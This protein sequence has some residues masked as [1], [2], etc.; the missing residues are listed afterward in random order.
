MPQGL[1]AFAQYQ[2]YNC[3][4]S[5]ITAQLVPV[6][7]SLMAP[8]HQL[9]YARSMWVQSLCLDISTKGMPVNQMDML[10][11]L[12]FLQQEADKALGALH[13]FCDAIWA[14]RLNPNSWQQVEVHFYEVL[15]LPPVWKYDFKTKQR[16]RGTDRDSLEKLRD[17]YPSVQPFVNAVLAYREAVKLAGVFKKGLEADNTLRCN[18]SPTGTETRRLS[19][20]TNPFGRGT[21]AQNLNDR[22]RQVIEAPAGYGLAYIDLKTAE[23]FAVGFISGSLPYIEAC[24]SGDLHTAVARDTWQELAWTGNLKTDKAIAEERFY[25]DFSRRDMTKK[26]GHASNYYGKPAQIHKHTKIDKRLIE[27]FQ[28]RYFGRYPE[29]PE[30][31]LRTIANIQQTGIIEN[32]FGLQRMFWGR[33]DDEATWREAIAHEPQGTVAEIINQGLMQVQVWL[34]QQERLLREFPRT[35]LLMQVHDAGLFCFPIPAFAE[36]VAETVQRIKVPVH[37]KGIGTMEIPADSQA[38]KNWGKAKFDKAKG[39]WKNPA[40]LR[41]YAPG[42]QLHFS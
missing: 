14:P 22:V 37:Y 2:V 33:R 42:D 15:D 24:S 29:I 26:L 36:L 25:R 11:L 7:E 1:N 40:G 41:D 21:N 32:V 10:T 6:M 23:S 17:T 20:Q 27:E 3:L 18:V 31:H 38:G 9:A 19:S 5:S 12:K 30:W 4:D 8:C 13:L 39:V 34:L 28:P 16:K 35:G